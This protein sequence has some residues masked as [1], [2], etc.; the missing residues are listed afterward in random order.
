MMNWLKNLF[1]KKKI[2]ENHSQA[3]PDMAINTPDPDEVDEDINSD[4][5]DGDNSG[6]GE[7]GGE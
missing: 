3:N 5:S 7:N 1:S 2:E 6:K 4:L